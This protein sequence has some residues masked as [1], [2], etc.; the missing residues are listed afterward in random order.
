MSLTVFFKLR[1][2]LYCYQYVLSGGEDSDSEEDEESSPVVD[3]VDSSKGKAE[4]ISNVPT[5][6]LLSPVKQKQ[7]RTLLIHLLFCFL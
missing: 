6:P 2:M 5:A 3:A 4:K 1:V 7:G